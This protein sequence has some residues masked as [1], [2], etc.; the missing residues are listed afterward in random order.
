MRHRSVKVE[1]ARVSEEVRA[2]RDG[3]FCRRP[4]DHEC[5]AGPWESPSFVDRTAPKIDDSP[6]FVPDAHTRPQ[7]AAFGKATTKLSRT[8]L[9]AQSHVPIT[10]GGR[11]SEANADV[12]VFVMRWPATVHRRGPRPDPQLGS[13]RHWYAFRLRRARCANVASLQLNTPLAMTWGTG[14]RFARTRSGHQSPHRCERFVV[15][16]ANTS[17]ALV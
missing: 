8:P 12:S 6:P 3:P 5:V 9:K 10:D 13:A 2:Q 16:R 14:G 7:L 1:L 4:H 17:V 11:Q 15:R